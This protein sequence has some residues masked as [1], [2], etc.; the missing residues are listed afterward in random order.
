ML[1]DQTLF[2][3]DTLIELRHEI[4]VLFVFRKLIFQMRTGSHPMGL[5]VWFLVVPF[6]YFHTS[7]VRTSKALARLRGCAG[8]PEPLLVAYVISTIISCAGSIVVII[9]CCCSL[10]VYARPR[11]D[12]T[13]S[14]YTVS[15][16]YRNFWSLPTLSKINTWPD[17]NNHYWH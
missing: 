11:S 12:T 7:C 4:M 17:W 1:V 8:S 5:D 6:V 13:K 10:P 14:I 15:S 9:T 3:F 16:K 2:T